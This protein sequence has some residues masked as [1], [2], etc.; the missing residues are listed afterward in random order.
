MKKGF[1]LIELLAV[2]AILTI[3]A[4]FVVPNLISLFNN[5]KKDTFI[6]DIKSRFNT[7]DLNIMKQSVKEGNS[8]IFYRFEDDEQNVPLT[9]KQ[10]YYYVKVVG[11]GNITE[12][13]VWD[14]SNTLKKKDTNGI[15][16]T[17][18]STDDIVDN[19]DT[20][21][22]NLEKAKTIMNGS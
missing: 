14:G 20:S 2:I 19:V 21:N 3:L 11:T 9:G 16:I 7:I 13:L 10:L 5:S 18:L 22:M 15:S 6:V 8:T 1:S 4:I 12:M 17:N